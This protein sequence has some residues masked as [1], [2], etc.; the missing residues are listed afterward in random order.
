MQKAQPYII[1]ALLILLIGLYFYFDWRTNKIQSELLEYKTKEKVELIRVR[2]SAS[3][4]I[5]QIIERSNKRID[6][7]ANLPLKIKYVKYEK[8]YY[9]N[10]DLDTALDILSGF[11]YNAKPTEAN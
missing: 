7:I 3:L 10:V 8:S 9:Y 6:S 11:K 1:I 5:D 2:D 4:R